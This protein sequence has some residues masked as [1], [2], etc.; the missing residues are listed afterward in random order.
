MGLRTEADPD[1]GFGSVRAGSEPS[2]QQFGR[3]RGDLEED[4]RKEVS[5]SRW[6]LGPAGS[7][8]AGSGSGWFR[9][10]VNSLSVS[11]AGRVRTG[12]VQ[13]FLKV[14]GSF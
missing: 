8:P 6:V 11:V 5:A 13:M 3:S 12:S 7:G 14:F 9:V 10:Q 4:W 2:W 1:R